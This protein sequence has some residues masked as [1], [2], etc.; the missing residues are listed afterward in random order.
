MAF[1]E[2][3][4]NYIRHSYN[5]FVQISLENNLIICSITLKQNMHLLDGGAL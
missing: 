5:K 1:T 3:C 2:Q 4:F